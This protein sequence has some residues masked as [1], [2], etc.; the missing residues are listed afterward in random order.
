[1]KGD[2]PVGWLFSPAVGLLGRLRYA[3]KILVV[4]VVLLLLLGFVAKAYVDLQR[5]Q[6]AFS[7][8]ER[9]GVAYLVPLLDLTAKA[10]TARH[11]AVTGGGPA[12]GV[13]DAVAGVDSATGRY[14]A[15]LG[16]VDGWEQAKQA[17]IRAGTADGPQAA[18]DAYNTAVADLL[19]LIVKSSDESNLTLDPDLDTYYLMDALVFRLPILLDAAGRAVDQAALVR[20]AGDAADQG[21]AR[22]DLAIAAG[23]LATTRDAIDAGLATAVEKTRSTTLRGRA[24]DGGKAVHDAVSRVIDQATQAAKSGDMTRLGSQQGDESRA[25]TVALAT[26]LAPELDRLIDVRIGGFQAKAVRVEV[27]IALV[28]L[29]VAWLLVGL[30][31]SAT[32]PLHRMVAALGALATGDLTRSVPV[33]T[34]DELGQMARALNHAIARVRNAVQAISGSA[35]GLAGSSGELST[36]SGS[37]RAAAEEASAQAETVGAAA[38]QVSRNVDTVATG[39]EEMTASISEIAKSASQAADVAAEAVVIAEEANQTV[40][41]LGASSAEVGDVVRVITAIA[42]QT[43]LLALNATIEASRAGEAGRGFAVVAGEVKELAQQTSTA[44]GEIGRRIEAIQ[45]DTRAAVEAIGGI[46]QVI[47]RINEGVRDA[48]SD[49][50]SVRPAA[51]VQERTSGS[52][53][54]PDAVRQLRRACMARQRRAG[55]SPTPLRRRV[56]AWT[57]FPRAARACLA[58]PSSVSEISLSSSTASCWRSSGQRARSGRVWASS[59]AM[60]RCASRSPS[61]VSVTTVTRPS[62]SP[63]RR[64]TRPRAAARSTRWLTFER[65]QRSAWASSP[66]AA[67]AIAAHSSSACCAVR[68]RV[69]LVWRKASSSATRSRPSACGTVSAG[70]WRGP[71]SLMARG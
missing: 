68:P 62:S 58:A 17:L 32:V 19:A 67:G 13:Q 35:G 8:K 42:E 29:L 21:Q 44:T 11:L 39:T 10:V 2:G 50:D 24:E 53:D 45:A 60:K 16:T 18:F 52:E 61:A 51:R 3:Y 28:V 31:R 69:R 27:A 66:T 4:P 14:G 9:V 59:S 23:T 49:G 55:A 7:V 54:V 1:M 47:G 71:V 26:A 25:A 56:P 6:V 34:R 30:Y 15:E 48:R 43:N 57:P 5:G 70:W 64:L 33:E 40:S 41:K 20:A 46:G 65:S 38:E 22:V 37:L 36:V 63:M 12:A